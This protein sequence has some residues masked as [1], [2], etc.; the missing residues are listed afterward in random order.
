MTNNPLMEVA[1]LQGHAPYT[2]AGRFRPSLRRYSLQRQQSIAGI[3]PLRGENFG[4][5]SF[6]A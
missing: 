4:V 3:S 2:L 5:A 6:L 1:L